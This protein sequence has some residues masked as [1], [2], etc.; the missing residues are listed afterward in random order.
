MLFDKQNAKNCSELP[1]K[2]KTR[3]VCHKPILVT[4][5]L[6]PLDIFSMYFHVSS[7]FIPQFLRCKVFLL[8]PN[9][10]NCHI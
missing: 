5:I 4:T 9:D 8:V 3:R 7:R 1:I 2:G 10:I 6:A